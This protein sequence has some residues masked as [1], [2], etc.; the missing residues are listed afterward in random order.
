MCPKF[1][2]G[3]YLE[4]NKENQ[5]VTLLESRGHAR[6]SENSQVQ[7]LFQPPFLNKTNCLERQHVLAQIIPYLKLKKVT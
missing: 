7:A 6:E 2:H 4:E 1:T 3:E 5:T